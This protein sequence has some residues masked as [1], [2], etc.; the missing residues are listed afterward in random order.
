MCVFIIQV[1]ILLVSELFF[2]K[3]YL[4]NRYG[5]K[6]SALEAHY[7]AELQAKNK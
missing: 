6:S 7:H 4:N 1:S 3:L 2:C 5:N